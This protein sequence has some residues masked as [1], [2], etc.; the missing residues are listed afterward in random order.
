MQAGNALSGTAGVA[1]ISRSELST[2][3]TLRIAKLEEPNLPLRS[4]L[5]NT[6]LLWLRENFILRQFGLVVSQESRTAPYR[7][8]CSAWLSV[9]GPSNPDSCR[10]SPFF[11]SFHELNV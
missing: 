1:P 6:Q 5:S 8:I 7:P 3:K 2:A 10:G 9:T 11:Q 4:I